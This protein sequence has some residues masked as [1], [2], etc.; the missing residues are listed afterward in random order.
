MRCFLRSVHFPS[1][2]KTLKPILFSLLLLFALPQ[3]CAQ[4]QKVLTGIH[5][6]NLYNL[7]MDEHS[8]YADFYI[9]FKWKGRIDPTKIEFVNLIEKWSMNQAGFDG[10]ST[11]V[12]LKDGTNYKIYRIEGRFFHSF[13]LNRYPLDEHALDIQVEN[14]DYPIDSLVYL[15]D[16]NAAAIRKSLNMVGWDMKGCKLVSSMQDYGTNFGNTQENARSYSN[17]T[18]TATLSRP[19]SYFLLKMLLPLFVVMLVS[20]GALLLHPSYIDTRSSL[21]IGGLLTAVFL[22]QMYGDTLPDTGYMVLMDKIYLL[23]YALISLVMLQII[24]AGNELMKHIS[25]REIVQQEKRLAMLYFAIF[26]MG[27]VVMVLF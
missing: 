27:V 6:M 10:D 22:Q 2:A 25:D 1:A 9:W 5:L 15:P 23:C 11:P 4:P 20:I 17:L 16:T 21:P 14:P 24:V 7:N 13:S 8:F 18:F 26:V 3:L 19:F 12:K